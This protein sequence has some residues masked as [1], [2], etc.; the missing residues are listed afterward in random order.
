MKEYTVEISEKAKEDILNLFYHI[1]AGYKSPLTAERY[2]R[3][4]YN[5]IKTL[6]VSAEALPIQTGKS[7]LPYGKNARCINYK[8]MTIIYTIHDKVVVCI[9]RVIPGAMITDL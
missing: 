3:G 9:C 1:F 8:K 5:K 4:L 6:S 2:V 7:F